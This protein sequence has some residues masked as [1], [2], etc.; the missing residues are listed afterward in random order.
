[1]KQEQTPTSHIRFSKQEYQRLL[2][3]KTMTGKSIPWLLKTAYFK[4]EISTPT[5]DSETRQA[6]RRELSAIGNNLNQLT[7]KVHSEIFGNLKDEIQDCIQTIRVL[8][9]YLGQDYGDR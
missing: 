2:K 5:L 6:V 7:K 9:S 4:K 8:K 1:M 3:D